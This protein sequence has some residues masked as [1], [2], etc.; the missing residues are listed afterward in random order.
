M[1]T[2]NS[3]INSTETTT[4]ASAN[5]SAK[6]SERPSKLN[7]ALRVLDEAL[8]GQGADLKQMVTDEYQNLRSAIG[9]FSPQMSDTLR[10]AGTQAYSRMSE[11]ASGLST[12][13]LERGRQIYTEVDA[14]VRANP[15]PILGGVA[16]G[17]FALGF[18]L[19]RTGS[20]SSSSAAPSSTSYNH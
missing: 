10:Q 14:T 12:T 18:L 1:A 13:G 4:T 8:S 16:V 9:G 11:F 19:G 2:N 5:G 6:S 7:D 15:W 20:S 17:T 3:N